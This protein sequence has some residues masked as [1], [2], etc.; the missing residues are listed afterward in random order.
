MKM[1]NRKMSHHIVFK[2]F[3]RLMAVAAIGVC[4][5]A[6]DVLTPEQRKVLDEWN[7]EHPE[8][9]MTAKEFLRR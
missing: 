6:D 3:I 1:D 7:A 9:A 2:S 8:M 4:L 5:H